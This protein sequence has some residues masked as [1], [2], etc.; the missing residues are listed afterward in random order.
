MTT[1]RVVSLRSFDPVVD[2]LSARAFRVWQKAIDWCCFHGT[3]GALSAKHIKTVGASPADVQELLK[4]GL[5]Q[6][7]EDGST[8]VRE[9]RNG[10]AVAIDVEGSEVEHLSPGAKRQREW[11]A[12][13][14]N[15]G[16]SPASRETSLSVTVETPG[17]ITL[18]TQRDV[19]AVTKLPLAS[20]SDLLS[21][22]LKSSLILESSSVLASDPKDL[23]GSARV[24]KR[25]PKTKREKGRETEF[26]EDFSV[27][28]TE[29]NLAEELGLTEHRER[30]HFRDKALAHGWTAKDWRARYR[31]WLRKAQEFASSARPPGAL[32]HKERVAEDARKPYHEL[33]KDEAPVEAASPADA[34]QAIAGYFNNGGRRIG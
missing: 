4:A 34:L 20:P 5:W 7:D 26:P 19:S 29:I 33:F 15:T 6:R 8:F 16:P 23:T 11:R 22:D 25:G 27:S 9:L 24:A 14:R 17:D 28:E 21:S 1:V 3:D 13:K 30:A 32:A 2:N 10:P 12:R 31:T 18:E